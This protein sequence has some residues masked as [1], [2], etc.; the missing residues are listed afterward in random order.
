[1]ATS[2]DDDFDENTR[3]S[4]EYDASDAVGCGTTF[5]LIPVSFVN[6]FASARSRLWLPPTESPMNVIDWPPYSFLRAA[7][8]GT[9][10][11]G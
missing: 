10:G 7:A 6:R 2:N 9:F 8:F 1:M 4:C 5:T 3:A 11:A